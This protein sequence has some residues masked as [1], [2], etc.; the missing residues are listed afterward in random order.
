MGALNSHQKRNWAQGTGA[1]RL[2][3][4]GLDWFRPV[5]RLNRFGLLVY[6]A[7][8][9]FFPLILTNISLSSL[10]K[11]TSSLSSLILAGGTDGGRRW[12]GA[13]AG[14]HRRRRRR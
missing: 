8:I 1:G 14:R 3:A 12:P 11:A 7:C 10:E 4:W 13:A 5:Q 9:G 2:W 6:I